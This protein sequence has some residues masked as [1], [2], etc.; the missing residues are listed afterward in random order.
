MSHPLSRRPLT[1]HTLYLETTIYY[2]HV[3]LG[4]HYYTHPYTRKLLLHTPP[5]PIA[6]IGTI[7]I[8]YINR[9]RLANFVVKQCKDCHENVMCT[10][11]IASFTSHD[12]KLPNKIISAYYRPHTLY[13]HVWFIVK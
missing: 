3:V 8:S 5:I 2:T 13:S 7:T 11:I 12:G 1:P 6:G 9:E 4:N 10:D